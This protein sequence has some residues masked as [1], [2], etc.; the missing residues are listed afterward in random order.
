MDEMVNHNNQAGRLH[1]LL[2]LAT[3]Q[4]DGIATFH[5]WAN[6]FD[7]DPQKK[8]EVFKMIILLQKTSDD[9]KNKITNMEGINSKLLLSQ[10]T[11]IETVVNASNLDVAWS[12]YKQYLNLAVMLN[13]AHCAEA[14]SKYDE[15]QIDKNELASLDSEILELFNRVIN[16]SLDPTLK[17]ILL[18]LLEI[19]R[20]SIAEYKIRGANGIRE[21]LA[22]FI[23]KV[24]Q[25]E[26]LIKANSASEEVISL[27]KIFS[28]ADN[29][30]TVAL[31]VIHIGQR[32]I[33]LLT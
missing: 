3:H 15:K 10:H 21:E 18:D 4:Q 28:R 7:I 1:T 13:L 25:N 8:T 6:V 16:G 23:G 24:V 31:N 12:S 14:L 32:I 22:Y 17:S 20:R 19:M 2:T 5:A 9:V 11:N 29:L 26:N 33:Q 30:T 27:W